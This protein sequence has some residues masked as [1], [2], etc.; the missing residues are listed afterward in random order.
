MRR[1]LLDIIDHRSIR[2]IPFSFHGRV[3]VVSVRF[4]DRPPNSAERSPKHTK[5]HERAQAMPIRN[6]NEN[7]NGSFGRG[8]RWASSGYSRG[9]FGILSYL[10]SRSFLL[11]IELASRVGA[12]RGRDESALRVSSKVRYKERAP[13]KSLD[14]KVDVSSAP[15]L[16]LPQSTRRMPLRLG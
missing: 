14:H 4:V 16:L 8:C 13:A 5:H 15:R 12:L 2:L 3:L 9:G 10:S 11:T 1:P 6:G 7:E